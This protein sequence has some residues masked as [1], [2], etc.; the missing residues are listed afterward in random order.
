[1]AAFLACV[2]TAPRYHGDFVEPR[3]TIAAEGQGQTA[4]EMSENKPTL[5][6]LRYPQK[7]RQAVQDC[8]A[9][10]GHAGMRT[11]RLSVARGLSRAFLTTTRT[12]R[13]AVHRNFRQ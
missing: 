5:H 11:V 9:L 10:K 7:E 1:M 8:H 2:E 13:H 4:A 6:R 12:S 3:F